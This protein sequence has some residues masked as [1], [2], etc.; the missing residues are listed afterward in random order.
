MHGRDHKIS[1]MG[2]ADDTKMQRDEV[3][4]LWMHVKQFS[5]ENFREKTMLYIETYQGYI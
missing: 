2:I 4:F 5:E 1:S 3:L